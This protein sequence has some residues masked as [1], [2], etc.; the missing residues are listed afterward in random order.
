MLIITLLCPFIVCAEE[1][2]HDA[3]QFGMDCESSG[4]AQNT[5]Y[6]TDVIYENGTYKLAGEINLG[7]RWYLNDGTPNESVLYYC[8]Q[9]NTTECESVYAIL[10]QAN[11]QYLNRSGKTKVTLKYGATFETIQTMYVGKDY[12]YENGVYTLTDV[13]EV[14]YKDINKQEYFSA[15][16]PLYFICLNTFELSCEHLGRL[17]WPSGNI[18]GGGLGK[19]SSVDDYYLYSDQFVIK[20]NQFQLVNPQ[21]LYPSTD[22]GET[23]YT[24]RSKEDTCDSLYRITVTDFFDVHFGGRRSDV[25]ELDISNNEQEKEVLITDKVNISDYFKET[26][27]ASAF[28]TKPE[29]AEIKDG[30][31]ILYRVG[32]TDLIYEDDLTYKVIHLTVTDEALSGNPKTHSTLIFTI[33]LGL[34]LIVSM[35]AF[36]KRYNV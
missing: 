30:K 31:L 27:L 18:A 3:Y 17:A 34:F 35:L 1:E 4:S 15:N 5:Y 26:E 11:C 9:T 10:Y 33:V 21:K 23:G 24:C 14:D 28:S 19:Y 29:I 36:E 16:Y 2:W 22:K 13:E 7:K 6:S 12:S 20:N 32:T 25:T 8:P